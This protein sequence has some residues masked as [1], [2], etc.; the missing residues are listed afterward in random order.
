[1]HSTNQPLKIKAEF[2]NLIQPLSA[3]EFSQLEQ[4]ILSHG[5]CRDAIKVWRNF[6]IDGHNRYE[7]CRKHGLTYTVEQLR[8]P[9]KEAVKLWIAENQLGRCNLSK[10]MRIEIARQKAEWLR[11]EAKASG[12]HYDTRKITAEI[13]G[14]GNSTVYKYMRIVGGGSAELVQRVRQGET[15][16]GAAYGELMAD[17]R[18][19][20]VLYSDADLQ[21]KN[22]PVCRD[23][24]MNRLDEAASIY[25][26][27]ASDGLA[28]FAEC[29]AAA[30]DKILKTLRKQADC[31]TE[32]KGA[33]SD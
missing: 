1:M 12:E 3:D 26:C 2:K 23:I 14:V 17:V 29:D 19:V 33:V 11:D 15:T 10:A 16:I 31:L 4:N 13:A 24:V 21:Y 20:T 18:E 7:I 6:I 8:F 5:K 22:T 30:F 25:D 28:G 27:L 9:S 32:I